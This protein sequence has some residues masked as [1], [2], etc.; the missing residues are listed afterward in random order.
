VVLLIDWLS[1]GFTS[2]LI[3]G[4]MEVKHPDSEMKRL[5]DAIR[6]FFKR[7]WFL[8]VAILAIVLIVTAFELLG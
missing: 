8:F 2:G 7:E 4:S 5:F 6:N 1:R 3:V